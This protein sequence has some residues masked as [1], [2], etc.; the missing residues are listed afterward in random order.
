M[1]SPAPFRLDTISDIKVTRF[2]KPFAVRVDWLDGGG[3]RRMA[4]RFGPVALQLDSDLQATTVIGSVAHRCFLNGWI[5][6]L[7]DNK[8]LDDGL[9]P[10]TW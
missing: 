5:R 1:S 2:T 7:I 9:R 3:I 4:T 10:P 6:G 8:G